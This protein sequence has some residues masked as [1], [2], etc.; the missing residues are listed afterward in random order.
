MTAEISD[1]FRRFGAIF[2]ESLLQL[3][4]WLSHIEMCSWRPRFG[5]H[6]DI[7]VGPRRG[8]VAGLIGLSP[9]EYLALQKE[10]G[11]IDETR[12]GGDDKTS[13][14]PRRHAVA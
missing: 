4:I 9:L 3:S 7:R 8:A 13:S 10:P 12:R 5:P 11:A 6:L 2:N 1:R 14:L